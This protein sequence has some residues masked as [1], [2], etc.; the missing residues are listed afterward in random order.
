[1]DDVLGNLYVRTPDVIAPPSQSDDR[2]LHAATVYAHTYADVR[3]GRVTQVTDSNTTE[4]APVNTMYLYEGRSI[5]KLQNGVIL[6]VFKIE[7]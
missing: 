4:Q 1:M 3:L 5:N 7:K 6:L 2:R